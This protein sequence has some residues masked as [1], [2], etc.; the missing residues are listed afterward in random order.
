MGDADAPDT[1]I[2]RRRTTIS[3]GGLLERLEL[4]FLYA[5]V[6]ARQ[7]TDDAD[8]IPS[9]VLLDDDE[10][11]LKPQRIGAIYIELNVESDDR[12]K[13]LVPIA[14]NCVDVPMVAS[15]APLLPQVVSSAPLNRQ[16]FSNRSG[17]ITQREST[18]ALRRDPNDRL[19]VNALD[20]FPV[21]PNAH[22][23]ELQRISQ[24]S[25]INQFPGTSVIRAVDVGFPTPPLSEPS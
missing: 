7:V 8:R 11:L 22:R 14:S 25:E 2:I 17:A 4:G 18:P 12:R 9:A 23:S 3:F 5:G 10:P 1:A 21:N 16:R 19:F 20:M 6:A 15:A 13:P 24:R